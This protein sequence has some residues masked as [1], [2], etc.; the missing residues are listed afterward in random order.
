MKYFRF[1]LPVLLVCCS[2]NVFAQ[3]TVNCNVITFD[4][5]SYYAGDKS[6]CSQPLIIKYPSYVAWWNYVWNCYQTQTGTVYVRGSV[7]TLYAYG[8]W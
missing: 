3:G 4:L 2:T 7:P 5:Q 6:V 1:L 8:H